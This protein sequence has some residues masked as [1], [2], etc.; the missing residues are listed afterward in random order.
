[1]STLSNAIQC[2]RNCVCLLMITICAVVT[3]CYHS[4]MFKG[5]RTEIADV[6]KFIKEADQY[7]SLIVTAVNNLSTTPSH[8][9][10]TPTGD[11]R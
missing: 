2:S 8:F 3:V 7:S 11:K 6:K 9:V 5:P 10:V 1:M 4:F